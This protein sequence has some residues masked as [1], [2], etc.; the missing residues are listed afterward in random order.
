[1]SL[2]SRAYTQQNWKSSVK[3]RLGI[4]PSKQIMKESDVARNLGNKCSPS[5]MFSNF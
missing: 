1:M 4:H 3:E 5:P 2:D